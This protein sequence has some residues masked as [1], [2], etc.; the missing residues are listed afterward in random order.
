MDTWNEIV[1][2]IIQRVDLQRGNKNTSDHTSINTTNPQNLMNPRTDTALVLK[3]DEKHSL[4][5]QEPHEIMT[6]EHN[7][8]TILPDHQELVNIQHNTALDNIS[9]HTDLM[10]QLEPNHLMILSRDTSLAAQTV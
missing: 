8:P 4:M 3:S 6:I 10:T 7:L 5:I 2:D 1:E 9:E